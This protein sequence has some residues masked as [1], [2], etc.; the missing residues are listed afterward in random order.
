MNNTPYIPQHDELREMPPES[1]E[2]LHKYIELF[3]GFTIPRQSICPGHSTPFDYICGEFFNEQGAHWMKAELERYNI[4]NDVVVWACRGGLKT[5][6]AAIL[7]ILD[8]KFRNNCGVRVLG[9]SLDQSNKM[10][11]YFKT[12][13]DKIAK[14]DMPDPPTKLQTKFFNG[15]T[16][17]I[18]TQSEKS[19]RGTH[20]PRVRC[21]EVE[22]FKQDVW[23]AVQFVTSSVEGVS[24]SFEILSTMHKPYGLMTDIVDTAEEKGLTVLKWCLWE[25]IEKCPDSRCCDDCKK[26]LQR[27]NAGEEYSFFQ[28][29]QG[30]AKKVTEH[31]H[32]S[33]KIEDAHKMF[34]RSSFESFDAEMGCNRPSYGAGSFYSKYSDIF[35][36]GTHVVPDF[37]NEAWPLYVVMDGGF[38][39]PAIS[40]FQENISTNQIYAIAELRPEEIS[41]SGLV[42]IYW[43][44]M[45]EK[46][47]KKPS[48]ALCD[49]AATDLIS[50]FKRQRK[51]DEG[52]KL[53]PTLKLKPADNSAIDGY[54]A[55]RKALIINE[56]L[57]APKFMVCEG[58]IMGRKELRQLHFPDMVASKEAAERHVKKNDHF[59]DTV[60]YMLLHREKQ[61]R[62][63]IRVIG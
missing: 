18:L 25:V 14:G 61:T 37:Y 42:D 54:S 24:S 53:H 52:R 23:D 10:Y 26:I 59:P 22:D 2:W 35:P 41:P 30:K 20:V 34:I 27:D 38:H 46:G 49:P 51:D 4:I 19:V 50:E 3:L 7:S 12:L 55:V 60:R 6:S 31:R 1:P 40:F 48:I 58:C 57:G 9:G 39:H 33:I 13:A 11:G 63:R 36:G 32:P 47:F 62:V 17:E 5:F 29:C 15:A 43:E 44:F 16:M 56:K 28:A 8:C 21:D 45:E